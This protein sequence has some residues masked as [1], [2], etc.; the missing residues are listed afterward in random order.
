M[1]NVVNIVNIVVS[2]IIHFLKEAV[3]LEHQ[4]EM[5]DYF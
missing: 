1:C 5:L 2:Y 4:A 3:E